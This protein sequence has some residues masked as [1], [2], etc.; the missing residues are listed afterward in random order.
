[1]KLIREAEFKE[2]QVQQLLDRLNMQDE[3]ITRLQEEVISCYQHNE[4]LSKS[5]S[6]NEDRPKAKPRKKAAPTALKT[7]KDRETQTV[8]LPEPEAHASMNVIDEQPAPEQPH[9]DSVTGDLNLQLQSAFDQLNSKELLVQ[10]LCN[11]VTDLEASL[12]LLRTQM[13]DKVSQISFYEKHILELQGKI[14]KLAS[15]VAT[16]PEVRAVDGIDDPEIPENTSVMKVS[17]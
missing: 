6:H 8:L 16:E 17:S 14:K 4:P 9:R 12:S 15:E 7:S 10:Q 3:L 13:G 1:M 11:K 5:E 2:V